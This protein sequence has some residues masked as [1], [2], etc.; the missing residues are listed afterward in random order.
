MENSSSDWPNLPGAGQ[1]GFEIGKGIFHLVI[2]D[3]CR[4]IFAQ[5]HPNRQRSSLQQWVRFYFSAMPHSN[6]IFSNL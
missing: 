4:P 1:V 6:G 2:F 5:V 3:Q